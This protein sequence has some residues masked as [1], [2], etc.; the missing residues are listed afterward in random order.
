VTNFI[1]GSALKNSCASDWSPAKKWGHE[2]IF[3]KFLFNDILCSITQQLVK[4]KQSDTLNS[5]HES[6]GENTAA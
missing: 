1:K 6:Y 4:Q 3:F 2:G 5:T